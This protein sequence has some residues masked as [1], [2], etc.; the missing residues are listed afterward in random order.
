MYTQE[1]RDAILARD[2]EERAGP[3]GVNA[4]THHTL[5]GVPN[6]RGDYTYAKAGPLRGDVAKDWTLTLYYEGGLR[7]V[8]TDSSIRGVPTLA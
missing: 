3:G 4:F 5:V 1:Q 8:V 2:V 7:R 6:G